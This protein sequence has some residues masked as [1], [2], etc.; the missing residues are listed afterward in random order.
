MVD[1]ALVLCPPDVLYGSLLVRCHRVVNKDRHLVAFI[2][3][4]CSHSLHQLAVRIHRTNLLLAFFELT[5][6]SAASHGMRDMWVE[7]R[8]WSRKRCLD[9]DKQG[10]L[11]AIQWGT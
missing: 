10:W 8:D 4:C 2:A 1:L 3:L 11:V 6:N 9:R 7:P 5:F